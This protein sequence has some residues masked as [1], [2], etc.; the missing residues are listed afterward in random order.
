MFRNI[1]MRKRNYLASCSITVFIF[2]TLQLNAQNK[3]YVAKVSTAPIIDGV[4]DDVW[5]EA[6]AYPIDH[7]YT[8][9]IDDADDCSATWRALWDDDNLYVMAEVTDNMLQNS[10]PNADKFWV[11]DCFEIFFDMLNEK[12]GVATD[13][14]PDD[15]KYQY[16][17]IYGLDDEPIF[18]QPPV[19]GMV[20]VSL[21]TEKGYNIEILLPWSTLIGP[22]PF[23]ELIIGRSIGT[24]FQVAD[25][26]DEPEEWM[27]DGNL[28]WN[29]P[30]G[31]A[32]KRASSFGTIILVE[33]NLPDATAPSTIT[34][35]TAEVLGATE[36]ALTWTS[37]GDDGDVGLVDSY[38]IRYSTEPINEENWENT[39]QVEDEV[40]PLISGSAQ[41]FTITG[42]AGGTVY[43][44]GIKSL[45]EAGNSS[46]LS[47]V[48]TVETDPA[49]EINPAA[50]T[51]LAI[52]DPR[53]ISLKITWTAPGDDENEGTALVYDIRYSTSE[54]TENNWEEA[55]VVTNI[56]DPGIAGTQQSMIII[57]LSPETSYYI[58]IRTTDEQYNSSELSNI[59]LGTTAAQVISARTPMDQ[60]IGTNAFIDDPLDKMQALGFIREYH[61]WNWDEGD[62]GSTGGNVI[63]YPGFPN[64]ENAWNPSYAGGGW[65]FDAYYKKLVDAGITVSPCVMGS[66]RWMNET[67]DFPS[68]NKPVREG[69]STTDPHSYKEHADHM[70]QYAARYGSTEV[71]DELLKLADNQPRISGL[72]YIRYLENWNEPDGDWDGPD[73]EF[74]PEELAA[75]G[76]ADRDG[77]ESSMGT[78]YGVKNADPNIKLVMG[79]TAGQSIDYI[80]RMRTWSMESRADKTFIYD[81][82]NVHKYTWNESPEDGGIKELMQSIVD[83]R[84]QFLPDVEVWITEFGWDSGESDTKFSCL[85]IGTYD[86]EEVQAQW[87]VRTYLLLA[88]SGVDRAAQF[89]LRDTDSDGL[90]WFQTCGLVHEK[91]DW[92]PKTSWYYV[93]T[94]RN[95]LKGTYF[96]GEVNSFNEDILLYKFQN[97][98]S[99]TTIYA[100]WAKTSD[101]SV[102]ENYR[103]NLVDEPDSITL[104][105]M[106]PG[107]TQGIATSLNLDPRTKQT[108]VDVSER[109]V[110][111]VTTHNASTDTNSENLQQIDAVVYPNPAE[112]KLHIRLKGNIGEQTYVSLY[113]LQGQKIILDEPLM[114]S[115]TYMEMDITGVQAGIYILEIE[116]GSVNVFKRIIKH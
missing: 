108:S 26:D 112:D 10:G 7:N 28:L 72:G 81:V 113:N 5:S 73:A 68:N 9:T 101:G 34:D 82:I 6:I 69:L 17:F 54:L 8:G 32:M 111:I 107:S 4:L 43:N 61:P 56:P 44:I 39:V 100:L 79:G 13:H 15:D 45:D 90:G 59:A 76:S 35:L 93:Y 12:N 49:D 98:E 20:N 99:D 75:M 57:G 103:L 3:G 42:L 1:S 53:P 115:S 58:G 66:T 11:H 105:E 78:T 71:A 70:F 89:M 22:H 46:P 41:N 84:D 37:K 65:N 92:S 94:M 29:N 52:I 24:E 36:V 104:R 67:R 38:D 21:D 74:S 91:N 102:I 50:I 110:F 87:M 40:A 97:A 116:T 25:L 31:D 114:K 47:N 106:I 86:K 62:I 60:F 55:S 85:S 95:I 2:L 30:T 83:Y 51:D 63:E 33:N 14:E 88:A 77:H 19:T 80:E 18:E 23:G 64:N 96:A 48:V 27:P 16:R 109:P